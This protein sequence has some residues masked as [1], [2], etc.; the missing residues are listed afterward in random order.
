MPSGHRL[1]ILVCLAEWSIVT[2]CR[3]MPS[4]HCWGD[5]LRLAQWRT[6]GCFSTAVIGE[7]TSRVNKN[8]QRIRSQ[9]CHKK[10]SRFIWRILWV[11]REERY[12]S[13]SHKHPDGDQ[14]WL[15]A[16]YDSSVISRE[17]HDCQNVVWQTV[18][19]L[20]LTEEWSRKKTVG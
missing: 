4:L 5:W 13:S 12:T 2:D 19:L 15:Q 16:T 11:Q 3:H 7:S 18:C 8:S 6:S 9:N 1:N 20:R 10:R 17:M 14:R